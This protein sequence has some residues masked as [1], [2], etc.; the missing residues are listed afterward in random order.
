MGFKQRITH[1]K[2]TEQ[3]TNTL[4]QYP[5]YSQYNHRKIWIK[6]ILLFSD[7]FL[8]LTTITTSMEK[9]EQDKQT[10][11]P[12]TIAF[13]DRTPFYIKKRKIWYFFLIKKCLAKKIF[14]ETP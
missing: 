9:K 4:I 8:L 3:N 12:T 2:K 7:F 13:T 11:K 14:K 5:E 1:Q 6:F 10:T